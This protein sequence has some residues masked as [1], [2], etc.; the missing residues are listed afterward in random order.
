MFMN[1]TAASSS[2]TAF[3]GNVLSFR[4]AVDDRERLVSYLGQVIH[5]YNTI[6]ASQRRQA[7]STSASGG[8][9]H[10]ILG[11]MNVGASVGSLGASAAVASQPGPSNQS[12]SAARPEPKESRPSPGV[13]PSAD[14]L[15]QSSAL[16]VG[17]PMFG[18]LALF[19]PVTWLSTLN[20]HY[21]HDP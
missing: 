10:G 18:C 12:Q 8:D 11:Q 3:G 14:Q 5:L 7:P 17:Y 21:T 4:P 20:L 9:Q 1:N 13:P 6:T 16:Q 15:S 19:L 2:G